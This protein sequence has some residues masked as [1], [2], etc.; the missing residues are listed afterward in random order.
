[1]FVYFSTIHTN[2][3]TVSY[4]VLI[5]AYKNSFIKTE[6][7]NTHKQNTLKLHPIAVRLPTSFYGTSK[8][9][10]VSVSR[11]EY[12]DTST[13]NIPNKFAM[14]NGAKWTRSF[15]QYRYKMVEDATARHTARGNTLQFYTHEKK[16]SQ[17]YKNRTVIFNEPGIKTN[18]P[19]VR[20]KVQQN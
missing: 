4:T 14:K 7:R 18:N 19:F 1:M 20:F 9:Y 8:L 3:Q 12:C 5:T 17:P 11:M 13:Y 6:H 2:T 15:A 10:S 16:N